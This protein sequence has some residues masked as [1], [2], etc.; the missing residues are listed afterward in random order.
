MKR[1]TKKHLAIIQ[2][3]DYLSLYINKHFYPIPYYIKFI[4]VDK[5]N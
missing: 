1:I 5:F 4:D 2:I 3:I